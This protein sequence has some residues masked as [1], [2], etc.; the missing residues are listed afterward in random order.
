[1]GIKVMCRCTN[2]HEMTITYNGLSR[3]FVDIQCGLL[4]GSSALYKF[5]PDDKSPIGKCGICQCQIKCTVLEE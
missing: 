4:D 2:G 3:E 5:P 1:M